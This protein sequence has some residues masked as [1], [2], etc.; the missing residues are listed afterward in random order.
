MNHSREKVVFLNCQ[1]LESQGISFTEIHTSLKINCFGNTFYR[2][3]VVAKNYKE[4]AITIC[5]EY[6]DNGSD[7][8]ITESKSF[9]SIWKTT[10]DGV[11]PEK[12]LK[13]SEVFTR[14]QSPIKKEK[15][16][17]LVF[18]SLDIFRD[19]L[20]ADFDSKPDLTE[21]QESKWWHSYISDSAY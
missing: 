5:R 9:F 3:Y 8:F 7:A 16:Q 2:V 18:S 1:F 11:E 6:L 14:Q 15:S 19:F 17:Q 10:N 4:K 13:I 12:K 20:E 21:H